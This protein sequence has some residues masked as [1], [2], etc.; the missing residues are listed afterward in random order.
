[1]KVLTTTLCYP[2][3]AQLDQGVFVQRRAAAVAQLDGVR[4]DVVAPQLWCPLFRRCQLP[5]EQAAPLRTI[6]PQMFSVPLLGRLTDGL[7]FARTLT[8]V[9][10]RE[11]AAN[12]GDYDL[13]DAHF[14]YPDGVGAWLAGRK[15]GIPVAVTVRG[16][17]VA[18]SSRAI[19][20]LQ[21]R[22]MLRGAAARIAV[23][24]SLAG[25]VRRVAGNDLRVDVIPNGVDAA[26]FHWVDRGRARSILGWDAE[27]KYVL[28]VGH[29]Q[30]LKGFDRLVEVWPA[31]RMALGDVRLVLV[32]SRRGERS[33]QRRLRRMINDCNALAGIDGAGP[34]VQLLGPLTAQDLNLMYNAADVMALASRS[35]GWCNA[36]SESL[37]TGTPVVAT[38]VGGNGEQICSPDLGRLVPSGDSNALTEAIIESLTYPWNRPG[39]AHHGTSRSW[40]HVAREVLA[41]FERATGK[42]A[43]ARSLGRHTGLRL[44][45]VEPELEAVS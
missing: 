17:I 13:I 31:V 37:A 5:A 40:S 14:E 27:R 41:V 22:A 33:F 15:L 3:P 20:R 28:S 30:W 35:E 19:R 10:E 38:D 2:T 26:T 9:I 1:M 16:K 43:T 34:C 39:I 18:L 42:A 45:R 6:Y 4:V 32:G 23:S 25:W 44:H 7:S 11:Q 29:A 36:I 24:E 12:R 21:I 8:A